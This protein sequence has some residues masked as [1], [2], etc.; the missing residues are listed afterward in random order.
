MSE[1]IADYTEAEI[2]LLIALIELVRPIETP[3]NNHYSFY[4]QTLETAGAY[5]RGLRQ[6]WTPAYNTLQ[7]RGLLS[8]TTGSQALTTDG[9]AIAMKLRRARPPIYYWYEEYYATAPHS[10]AYRSFCESLYGRY[11]CQ[12]G[13]SDMQQLDRLITVSQLTSG[14]SALDIG[15]GIGLIAD[16][17]SEI[18]DCNVVGFDYSPTAISCANMLAQRKPDKLAFHCANMDSISLPEHSFDVT[19]AIDTL[20]MPNDLVATLR[21]IYNLLKPNG[22]LNVYYTHMLSDTQSPRES[23]EAD[24]TPL[25]IGLS[26]S[27][28][29]WQAWDVSAETHKH[30][31]RRY[32]RGQQ[33]QAEFEREG[34]V[35]LHQFIIAESEH[36]TNAYDQATTNMRRYLYHA[37]PV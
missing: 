24:K 8:T 9:I 35:S 28:Y 5:F 21:Q 11:L 15:C 18:T 16:Y 6:D 3:N 27:G 17:V 29:Q 34:N 14:Q 26:Q 12:T 20:Y 36:G 4:P 22:S 7:S 25:A 23:L 13:F 37:E 30:L 2:Q 32:Q 10:S 33:M 1:A 31:Q 19:Y